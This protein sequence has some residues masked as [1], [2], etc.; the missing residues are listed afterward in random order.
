MAWIPTTNFDCITVQCYVIFM[1]K[2]KKKK[3]KTV[4]TVSC[5]T[6]LIAASTNVV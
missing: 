1:N 6:G 5:H 3:K 4:Y 2:K